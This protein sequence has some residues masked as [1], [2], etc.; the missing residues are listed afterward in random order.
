MRTTKERSGSDAQIARDP[1]LLERASGEELIA[2]G[3]ATLQGGV[4]PGRL[5]EVGAAVGVV[6]AVQADAASPVKIGYS[7]A[8]GMDDRLAG[9][10][11]G[12]PLR[13]SIIAHAPGYLSHER[14]A[15]KALKN[16]RLLGEWF[17]WSP[18][19][20]A[21]VKALRLDGIEAAIA[22]AKVARDRP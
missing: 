6:Y 4:L 9:L 2:R 19:V 15:H 16:D 21:F 17:G 5:V 10:Q 7:T 12:N 22:A 8:G 11:T 3:L 14:R 18:R 20:A 13:L 1:W